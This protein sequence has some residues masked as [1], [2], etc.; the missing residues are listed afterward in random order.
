MLFK[1][2]DQFHQS[3]NNQI[4]SSNLERAHKMRTCSG[5]ATND[6]KTKNPKYIC[7]QK[8]NMQYL[9]YSMYIHI[10]KMKQN[11]NHNSRIVCT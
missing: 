3:N 11:H 9:T 7:G 6:S 1:K 5:D 2:K 10:V 8:I 4:Q